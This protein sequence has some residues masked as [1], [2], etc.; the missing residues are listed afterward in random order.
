MVQ[1]VKN[2]EDLLKVISYFDSLDDDTYF[3]NYETAYKNLNIE[4]A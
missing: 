1:V 2:E 3:K 4:F